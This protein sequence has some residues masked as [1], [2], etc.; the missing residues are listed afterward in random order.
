MPRLFRFLVLQRTQLI[1]NDL[2]NVTPLKN[3]GI[4]FRNPLIHRC[5]H[6][7]EKGMNRGWEACSGEWSFA[8]RAFFL[9]ARL[10]P[11][12]AEPDEDEMPGQAGHD[13]G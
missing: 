4:T 9:R 2:C 10:N 1:T 7:S 6:C 5:V 3:K 12:A 11:A 8:E 13:G